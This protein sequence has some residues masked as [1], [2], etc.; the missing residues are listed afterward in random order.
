MRTYVHQTMEAMNTGLFTYF[1]HPDLLQFHGDPKIYLRYMR[2]IC[3][4]AKSCGI[5][6]EINLLGYRENKW[7]PNELFYQA[8]A[9]EDCPVIIGCDAHA[10]EVFADTETEAFAREKIRQ[11]GLTLLDTVE[12]KKI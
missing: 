2:Q 9:E 12:L 11:Y 10:P 1:A 3:R 4:E 6:V 8:A 5:P 7:Y